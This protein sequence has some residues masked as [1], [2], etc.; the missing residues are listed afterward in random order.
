M[1]VNHCLLYVRMTQ[2]FLQGQNIA[3]VHHEMTGEGMPQ[4]VGALPCRQFDV[5]SP[6]GFLELGITIVEQAA[7][8]LG[9]RGQQPGCNR[10]SPVALALGLGERDP[11]QADLGAADLFNLVA[12]SM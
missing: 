6:D 7:G 12:E 9:Q 1:C 8:A 4:N 3:A 2:Y 5:G 10:D 11:A